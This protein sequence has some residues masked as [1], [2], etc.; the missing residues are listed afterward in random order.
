MNRLS[1]DRNSNQVKPT[2]DQIAA[3]VWELVHD[4]RLPMKKVAK[5]MEISIAEAYELL[6][7]WTRRVDATNIRKAA[8]GVYGQAKRLFR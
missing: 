7:D 2:R 3:Q 4:Q 5:V 6:A 1:S 8:L